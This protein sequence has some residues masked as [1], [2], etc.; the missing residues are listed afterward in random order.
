M[1]LLLRITLILL[2]FSSCSKKADKSVVIFFENDVHCA[3]QG[4][5]YFAG[6]RNSV[7]TDTAFVAMTSAGDY[8]QGGTIGSI[9]R[10]EAIMKIIK[11]IGYDALAMGNHEFDY[12]IQHTKNLVGDSDIPVV[13][14]NITDLDGKPVFAP[15]RICEYGNVKVGYIGVTTPNTYLSKPAAFQDIAGNNLYDFHRF[16]L[17]EWVQKTV[18]EVRA[19]KADYVIVLSHVGEDPDTIGIT[20]HKLLAATSG[21]D[22]LF[23]GHT[24]SYVT[25]RKIK[26][27]KGKDVWLA[28]TG[29]FFKNAGKLVIGKDGKLSME[30]IPLMSA[31]PLQQ[32]PDAHIKQFVDSITNYY[33]QIT[34]MPVG[35]CDFV[36]EVND[37][38]G[39]KKARY[40]DTNSGNL[41]TDAMR[42]FAQ[43]DIAFFN[44]GGIR[45]EVKA[46]NIKRGDIIA[47]LPYE[48]DLCTFTVTGQQ[49]RDIL[50]ASVRPLPALNG[51]FL[52]VSGLQFE[53][54]VYDDKDNEVTEIKVYDKKTGKYVPLSNEATYE[55]AI[56]DYL[57]TDE[58]F[59][60][61]N[62]QF[63][64]LVNHH[65]VISDI[66]INF[67]H[68]NCKGKVPSRYAKEE[69]RMKILGLSLKKTE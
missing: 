61:M 32:E 7:N 12:D 64:D 33:G 35:E 34:E 37:E 59:L 69:T 55:V 44:G 29:E 9:S 21:I 14:A 23:D 36:L 13:C 20:S 27:C 50:T 45:T 5:P 49:I 6:L 15:Y 10:G 63:P 4:Y 19:K 40:Q 67:I 57:L 58:T 43:C 48:N 66:V 26:N 28:Q 53:A 39:Y 22:A 46:G 62:K 8:S 38:N 18:D 51:S 42:D 56:T 16:D 65:V 41:V 24:H 60:C 52:Q 31:E 54:F 1:K 2:L 25:P 11:E 47:L 17:Y 3:V 30:L 68:D